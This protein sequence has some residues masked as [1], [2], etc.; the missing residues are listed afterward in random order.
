MRIHEHEREER[1]RHI[2]HRRAVNVVEA[3]ADRD[4][5]SFADPVYKADG[6]TVDKEASRR[7]VFKFRM[8]DSDM[9]N[10]MSAILEG[11]QVE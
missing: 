4:G 8:K 3:K 5:R 7:V 9:I 11:Q 1:A 6:V 2:A 10:Q